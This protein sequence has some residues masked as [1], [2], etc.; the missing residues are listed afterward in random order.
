MQ[1]T[2]YT[3]I[4]LTRNNRLVTFKL[5]IEQLRDCIAFITERCFGSVCGKAFA[6]VIVVRLLRIGSNVP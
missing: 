1:I 6:D 2:G 3:P 4:S 5:D